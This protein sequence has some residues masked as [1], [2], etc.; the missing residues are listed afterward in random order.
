MPYSLVSLELASSI[1]WRVPSWS[2]LDLNVCGFVKVWLVSWL[3]VAALNGCHRPLFFG[4]C[5]NSITPH[6]WAQALVHIS[7]QKRFAL[8]YCV[9]DFWTFYYELGLELLGYGWVLNVLSDCSR[10]TIR[11]GL[12][13]HS[14][15]TIW[16]QWKEW[17]WL[18]ACLLPRKWLRAKKNFD[19]VMAEVKC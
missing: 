9:Q 19:C 10:L 7:F 12:S 18:L 15:P 1:F 5:Q 16:G 8:P 6:Q 11:Q 3:P 4:R 17:S 13:G 14:T 2:Q